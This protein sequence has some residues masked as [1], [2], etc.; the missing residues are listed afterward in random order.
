[1]ELHNKDC[2]ELM[3]EIES[4]TID[5]IL[6]DPPY[7]STDLAFDKAPRIDFE[8][9]LKEC[10]RVLKPNGI[11]VSFADFNLL[12]DLRSKKVFKSTY[13]LIW[14]KTT[15]MGF[16]DANV[17]P[18][19][20]HEFIGVFVDGLKSATYNPQKTQG[21]R[22]G[23]KFKGGVK[24]S[25]I[26]S[27]VEKTP[28]INED[29]KR[30]PLTI[31]SFID[32]AERYDTSQIGKNRHPTQKPLDAVSWLIKTYSNEGDTVLDCFMGSGST[33]VACSY[34]NRHFIGCELDKSYFDIAEK[35][36]LDANHNIFNF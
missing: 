20:N 10:K 16:L 11:L 3:A 14:H 36:I 29:G 33:G 13:E 18:L 32:D 34:N 25:I 15:P 35:R 27:D 31:L 19:R 5:L 28:Y 26:Y 24:S 2:R 23:L 9:W 7:Y 4:G 17:R 30:H 8:A 12:A 22:Y 21:K 6:T 1:M